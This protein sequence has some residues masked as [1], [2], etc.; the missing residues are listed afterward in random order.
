MRRV[1]FLM[2]LACFGNRAAYC[3]EMV[4]GLNARSPMPQKVFFQLSTQ[5]SGLQTLDYSNKMVPIQRLWVPPTRDFRRSRWWFCLVPGTF[6]VPN[7]GNAGVWMPDYP[8]GTEIY[9]PSL[10]VDDPWIEGLVQQTG[11]EWTR[12]TV[13]AH[14]FAHIYLGHVVGEGASTQWQ[15]EYDAD[16]LA[17]AT[18]RRL[19]CTLEQARALYYLIAQEFDAEDPDYHPS[20]SY[21]LKAV[22]EGWRGHEGKPY[23]TQVRNDYVGEITIEVEGTRYAI[24]SHGSI[25]VNFKD[26]ASTMRLWECPPSGCEW[27]EY[28]IVAGST[29][30]VIGL[31]N[32]T[33][34]GAY[35][36]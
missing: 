33:D 18:V 14:E 2:V 7:S 1:L 5:G 34:L 31:R 16:V 28:A 19:G 11:S 20:L 13:L 8:S 21:R 22:G 10:F 35:S 36:E 26:V 6:L 12:T 24:P 27:S 4:C 30:H 32:S 9:S 17:G 29:T 15:R 3:G 23:S 25:T